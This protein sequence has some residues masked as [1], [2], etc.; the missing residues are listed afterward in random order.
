MISLGRQPQE[1]GIPMTQA[2]EGRQIS[3]CG[4][5]RRIEHPMDYRRSAAGEGAQQVWPA[6]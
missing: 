2:P 6:R 1:T 3:D 4:V 5:S